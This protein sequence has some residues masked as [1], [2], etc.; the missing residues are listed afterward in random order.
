MKKGKAVRM[1]RHHVSN[2]Y[3]MYK[4]EGGETQGI[5]KPWHSA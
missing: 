1:L 4:S 5:L 3:M 2:M